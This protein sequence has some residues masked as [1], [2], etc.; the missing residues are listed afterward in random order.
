MLFWA[1]RRKTDAVAALAKPQEG[2]TN[3]NLAMRADN[4]AMRTHEKVREKE[5]DHRAE[6]R[7]AI[8]LI[9][10]DVVW[11]VTTMI[12][13]TESAAAAATS[14]ARNM[15]AIGEQTEALTARSTEFMADL[16]AVGHATDELVQTAGEVTNAVAVAR[17]RSD[18]AGA[19]ADSS[20]G[21]IAD[22]R[23]AVAEIGGILST[24]GAIAAKTNLLA[25]NATIEAARAGAAGR[26]FAV[27]AQEVKNLSD[28]SAKAV[29]AIRERIEAL[30][31]AS[32][33]AVGGIGHVTDTLRDFAPLFETIGAAATHQHEAIGDLSRRMAQSRAG[34]AAMS[35]SIAAINTQT[36][37]GAAEAEKARHFASDAAAGARDLNRRFKTVVRNWDFANRRRHPRLP[38]DLPVRL[39]G[40]GAPLASRAIDISFGGM[41]MRDVEGQKPTVGAIFRAEIARVG[42]VSLALRAISP[43]GWH[44][45]FDKPDAALLEAIESLIA[46]I[47]A[48]HETQI[49]LSQRAAEDIAKAVEAEVEAGRLGV[50][51]L[52][53]TT[54]T[55]I[56]N[57][58]P[59]QYRTPALERLEAVLIPVQER[60]VGQSPDIAFCAC[61]DRN[62]YLPV[63]NRIYSQ[64]QRP[65]DPVWNAAN[66]RNRRIFDDRA[67]LLAAR[68][69]E[70]FLLQSYMRDMGGG[71]TVIMKEIDV[72]LFFKGRHWGGL[73]TAYRL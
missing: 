25:L 48:S 14:G 56:P 62:G 6:L 43:L 33:R 64:P 2:A 67:G 32:D 30:Q 10:A 40:A 15:V 26:G 4:L 21:D 36:R 27:V 46:S 69:T 66:C 49:A 61:V 37:A 44:F 54:Y 52:F 11:A 73:R 65:D 60:I 35:D 17:Q 5:D 50:A 29:S 39:D 38:V 24:I 13:E 23:N 59:V 71:K 8:D 31:R 19:M 22:L 55:P 9:E 3:D 68:N 41:L 28:A 12:A 45:A 70:P 57:T 20:A 47:T 42:P 58:N 1:G 53:D 16:D 18:K 51:Q 7:E 72:P 63:H 34:V